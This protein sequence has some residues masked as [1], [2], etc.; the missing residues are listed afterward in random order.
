[1]RVRLDSLLLVA[2]LVALWQGLHMIAGDLALSSPADTVARAADLLASASF[3]DHVAASGSALGLALA[4]A[5]LGGVG[6]GV[7][8]GAHRL[9]GDVAEP[10]VIAFY[11]LPK[12][13]LYPV[14]LLVFGLGLSAKVAFGALHGIMPITVF[15]MGGIR[16]IDPVLLKTARVL[17]LSPRQVVW[18]VILPAILPELL[19]GLRVGLSMTLLGTLIGEMFAAKAGVGQ[20]LIRA[21]ARIDSETIL[22]LTLIMFVF[23]LVM[24]GLLLA[25]ERRSRGTGAHDALEAR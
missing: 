11:T 23:A 8:L 10:F 22:A 4:I 24:N 1:M 16:N 13:T 25:V 18:Q 15:V 3:W 7:W 19:A 17:R 12:I 20:L 9:S 2:A 21:I 14:I 5:A 6:L